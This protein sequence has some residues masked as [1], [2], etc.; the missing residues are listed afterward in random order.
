MSRLEHESRKAGLVG[1]RLQHALLKADF[2]TKLGMNDV[3]ME[4]LEKALSSS[5]SPGV[6]T[7]RK[8]I[9]S[10]MQ[11]LREPPISL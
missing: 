1:L 11:E 7:L 10:K 8:R 9:V 5:D 3:A 4:T 6:S 2:Q